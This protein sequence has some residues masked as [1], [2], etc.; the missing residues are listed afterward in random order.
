MNC[1]LSK[2]IDSIK[3][4]ILEISAFELNN[5]DIDIDIDNYDIDIDNYD[6][7]IDIDTS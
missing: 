4:H 1:K 2:W 5:Y 3:L 7:D 6:I